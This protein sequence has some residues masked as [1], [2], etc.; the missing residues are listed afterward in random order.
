MEHPYGFG[1]MRHIMSLISGV[2]I[3]C[4]GSGVSVYH[5]IQVLLNPTIGLDASTISVGYSNKWQ[6]E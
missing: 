2:G 3:F 1:N 5:G 6:F 4:L